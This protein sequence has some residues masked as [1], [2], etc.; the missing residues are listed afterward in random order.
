MNNMTF[1]GTNPFDLIE[2]VLGG[3][4][5]FSPESRTPVIDVRETKDSYF[6]EAELPGIS[7]K[8]VTLEVKDRTLTLSTTQ[9]SSKDKNEEETMDKGRYIRKERRA[10]KFSR[11][12]ELP[13]DIDLEKIEAR[14]RDGLLTVELPRKPESA[15]RVVQVKAA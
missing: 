13:E 5:T 3:D 10:F 7:E 4:E 9:I 8:N 14:Y 12:F 1:Y 15:P 2:Q 11:S 6:I